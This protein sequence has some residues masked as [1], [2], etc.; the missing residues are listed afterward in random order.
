MKVATLEQLNSS[1]VSGGLKLSEDVQVDN[2]T[3]KYVQTMPTTFEQ[4]ISNKSKA[5]AVY[6]AENVTDWLLFVWSLNE[7]GQIVP[8]QVLTTPPK[9]TTPGVVIEA[10]D[11]NNVI[12]DTV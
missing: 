9:G 2:V 10:G 12:G 11:Q 4:L 7:E 3:Y 6:V 8:T 1:F 5:V